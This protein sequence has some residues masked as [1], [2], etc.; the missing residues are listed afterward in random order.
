M[1]G[2]K[3]ARDFDASQ[4]M[5]FNVY[6][7][8]WR[9]GIGTDIYRAAETVTNWTAPAIIEKDGNL[10]DLWNQDGMVMHPTENAYIFTYRLAAEGPKKKTP[11]PV[12]K[13]EWGDYE[14]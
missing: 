7:R 13:P 5:P 8:Y 11:T 1:S 10:Y 14:P 2:E 3:F 6:Y 12:N 9:P 4:R